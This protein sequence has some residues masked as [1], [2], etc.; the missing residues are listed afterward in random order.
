MT[1]IYTYH[2]RLWCYFKQVLR[3][4]WNIKCNVTKHRFAEMYYKNVMLI[5]SLIWLIVMGVVFR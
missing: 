4:G 5:I 1:D 3:W 2:L